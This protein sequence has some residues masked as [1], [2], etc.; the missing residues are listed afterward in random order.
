MAI[1]NLKKYI[2]VHRE[3]YRHLHFYGDGIEVILK[4]HL[5]LES[6]IEKILHK[7]AQNAKMISAANL[8]FYKSAC[9][10]QAI[11]E[12]KCASWVWKAVFD[13]N[14]IRNKLAHNLLYPELENMIEDFV[15][16]V[17]ANG[18]GTM[19]VGDELDFSELPMAIVNIHSELWR[20]LDMLTP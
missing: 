5:L 1:R 9:I 6:V 14:T 19:E 11:H 3:L 2:E 12:S 7:S 13:L 18:D 4:G 16:H 20:L 17:R 8:S 10:V 15:E